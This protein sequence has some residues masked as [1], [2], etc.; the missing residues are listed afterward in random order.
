M[1]DIS[2]LPKWAQDLL[3]AKDDQIRQRDEKILA[4]SFT[5][6]IPME[7]HRDLPPPE[8]FRELSKG[9]DFNVHRVM[10]RWGSSSAVFKACSSCVHH[11]E[12]WERTCTQRPVHLFSTERLAWMALR[13]AVLQQYGETLHAIEKR[14]AEL[15][16]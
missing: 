16:E 1:K 12:G 13:S 4:L 10:N 8:G 15:P 6:E 3:N 11:G 5:Q 9:W 14:I 2:K 7:V